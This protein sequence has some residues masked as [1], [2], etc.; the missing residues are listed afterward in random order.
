MTPRR[1]QEEPNS[2]IS[3]TT[4]NPSSLEIDG[5]I[6][7]LAPVQQGATRGRIGTGGPGGSF[8]LNR[9]DTPPRWSLEG[10]KKRLMSPAPSAINPRGERR[11]NANIPSAFGLEHGRVAVEMCTETKSVCIML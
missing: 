7:K 8:T 9:F 6:A 1:E 4:G 11:V 2:Y 10:R 3:A 5:L